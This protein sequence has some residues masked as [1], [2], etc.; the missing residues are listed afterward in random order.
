MGVREGRVLEVYIWLINFFL[1]ELPL[2]LSPD[3]ISWVRDLKR[4]GLLSL[5]QS[6]KS[7]AAYGWLG[8]HSTD[9]D[10]VGSTLDVQGKSLSEE[11]MW[12]YQETLGETS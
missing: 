2:L 3:P 8:H 9:L 10:E 4:G 6:A 11:M 1:P 12:L 7:S 5:G